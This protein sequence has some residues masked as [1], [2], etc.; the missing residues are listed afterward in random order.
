MNSVRTTSEQLQDLL[1]ESPDFIDFLLGLTTT[2]ASLL[3]K[4]GQPILCAITV[5]RDG[6]PATVAS[7]TDMARRLDEKQYAI[8]D[9]PCLTALREQHRVL[10]DDLQADSEWSRY[11]EAIAG[12]GVGSVLAVPIPT[13]SASGAALNC[14]ARGTGAFDHRTVEA[15][16][17]HAASV[18]RILRILR[19]ALRLHLPEEYP[20]HLREA[21]KSRATVDAAVSLIMLQSRRGGTTRSNSCTSPPGTA[22]AG[23]RTSPRTFSAADG[24][25]STSRRLT[26]LHDVSTV[27]E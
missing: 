24:R 21:L 9:G 13:D 18:S 6:G 12:E 10:I 26:M 25:L 3:G 2:S 17:E 1:L 11:A 23:S 19:L 4:D 27:V 20:E 22:A 5:Q 14:Y 16:E 7:S 15:I 8:G